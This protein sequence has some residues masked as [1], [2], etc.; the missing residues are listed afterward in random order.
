MRLATLCSV[1][2]ITICRLW[3]ADNRD[4][5]QRKNVPVWVV[6]LFSAKKLDA[7][8]EFAFSVNPFYL[9]GDFNGDGKSDIAILVRNKQ[10]GKIGIAICHA[11]RNEIFFVGAGTAVGNGGD[12]FSWMEVWRHKFRDQACWRGVAGRKERIRRRPD[13]LGREKLQL[14]TA[15]R[16][17]SLFVASAPPR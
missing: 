1:F 8:Y 2:A 13:L 9:R 7:Q 5:V 16:L 4:W 10:S 14:A 12:D 3:G 15:R 11:V 6:Q 17:G